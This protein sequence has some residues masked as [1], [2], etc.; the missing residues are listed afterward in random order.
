MSRFSFR[1]DAG[2]PG[3]PPR[4]S[5]RAALLL[6]AQGLMFGALVWR[7]K[8]LQIDAAERYLLLAEEN[9]INVRLIPPA[10]GEIFDRNG[11]PLAVNRQNHRVV[12][13]REQAG[14]VEAVLDDLDRLIGVP[15]HQRSRILREMRSKSAFVPVTVAEN[16][17]WES[18]ARVNANAPALPGV[19]PEV[20]LSRLYPEGET[21][22]HVLGYVARF[23]ESDRERDDA[24]DP[25][26][27]IPDFHIGKNGVERAKEASLRGAA[28]ASR[29]E[30]NAVGRV[31]REIDR[32]EGTPGAD[33][34]LTLD[35]DIQRY[36]M[37][38]MQGESSACVLIEI[39]T[40]DILALASAP[41]FEPNKFVTGISQSEWNALL[42]DDH[43]PLANKTV[44]GQYP[45]GSTFKMIVA[46]AGLEAGVIAPGEGVFCNGGYRLG[47]RTF[48]CWKRG[49]HGHVALRDALKGSCDVYFYEV[50]RRVGVDRISDMAVRFGLGPAPDLPMTA[51]RDGIAPTRAWKQAT[52]GE[53]WQVG[54]SLN[55][56]I[57]QGYVL[58]SPVQL[59]TMAA[60]LG[61]DGVAV[62]PRLIRTIAGQPVPI[63]PPAPLG[64]SAAHL[65]L[66]R[67]GMFAVSSERGGTAY[68]SRID[69]PEMLMAGK[70]GTSQVRRITVAER[71]RGVTRNEDLP[72]NRRDHALFVAF[73]PWQQPRYAVAV[74]VEHGG[75]GSRAAAPIA[76]DVMMRALYGG[77]PPLRAYPAGERE[78]IQ[79]QREEE[80]RRREEEDAAETP[81]SRA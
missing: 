54:D 52:Q 15:P 61:G 22:S 48:H 73:A 51:V 31:I 2:R 4:I 38:R 56:G 64:V 3:A 53:S 1:K 28:G 69:D 27:Q 66:V 25:L 18:F 16:L 26:F 72:W 59:A 5:R 43:R 20:G 78:E 71:A 41:G 79:R 50:A 29:I 45:P 30:V 39:E 19:Q 40:G 81:R 24:N 33:L 63:P 34:G 13:I 74:V 68:R 70:T 14:D 7:L 57:G 11:K 6:G 42:E 32:T 60:R 55:V 12:M 44:S 23:S 47:E 8:S 46:L 65:R 9:R 10:R 67:E 77:E 62:R 49:G 35:L 80:E 17:D 58:A 21:L 76:R 37:R 75:G 36:A